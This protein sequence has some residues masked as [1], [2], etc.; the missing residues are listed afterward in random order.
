MRGSGS[1]NSM[2]AA[3]QRSEKQ[4]GKLIALTARVIW[5]SAAPAAWQADPRIFILSN[6]CA[7]LGRVGSRGRRVGAVHHR[8]HAREDC[9]CVLGHAQRHGS[10]GSRALHG[11]GHLG[12]CPETRGHGG[13]GEEEDALCKQPGTQGWV[14]HVS[15][16]HTDSKRSDRAHASARTATHFFK[17]AAIALLVAGGRWKSLR[18]LVSK[19]HELRWRGSTKGRS[20]ACDGARRL[21][22]AEEPPPAAELGLGRLTLLALYLHSP[23]QPSTPALVL[24]ASLY[25]ITGAP[26]AP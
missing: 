18:G 1:T 15:M 2:P 23:N 12:E 11:D 14:C 8:L 24:A 4:G 16:W 22:Q 17:V 20:V 26:G 3:L 19:C 5:W 25:S 9:A 7:P 13:S 21:G 10:G 6:I